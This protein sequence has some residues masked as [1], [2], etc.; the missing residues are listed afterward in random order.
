M[1][2]LRDAFCSAGHCYDWCLMILIL[3]FVLAG[4]LLC[5]LLLH[6]LLQHG[7]SISI[8]HSCCHPSSAASTNIIPFTWSSGILASFTP[9]PAHLSCRASCIQE[10]PQIDPDSSGYAVF[11]T[12]STSSSVVTCLYHA[13]DHLLH[14]KSF[15]PWEMPT[16]LEK[17]V[18]V[19][20]SLLA[21]QAVLPWPVIL[22]PCNSLAYH[23]ERLPH[24]LSVSLTS[25]STHCCCIQHD[26]GGSQ[27]P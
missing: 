1:E 8:F 21:S 20:G 26:G 27:R 13:P 6:L 7:Y 17:F 25:L 18:D 3:R 19:Q 23:F 12:R 10:L 5:A 15:V 24:T 14:C 22:L 4:V 9:I 11:T 2:E 16:L